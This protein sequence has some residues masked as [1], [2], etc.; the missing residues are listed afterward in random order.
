MDEIK[1]LQEEFARAQVSEG[2]RVPASLAAACLLV[3]SSH[4]RANLSLY[5]ISFLPHAS[6]LSHCMFDHRVAELSAQLRFEVCESRS[7]R[8]FIR[9]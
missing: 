3:C 4:C 2:A 5:P 1:R 7:E 8:R 6:A 9:F